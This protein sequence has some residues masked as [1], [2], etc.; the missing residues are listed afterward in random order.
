MK[1]NRISLIPGFLL[2]I[3][4]LCCGENLLMAQWVQ[5]GPDGGEVFCFASFDTLLFAG[6][7]NGVYRSADDGVSWEFTSLEGYIPTLATMPDGDSVM[8]LFAGT[9][10]GGVFF[11]SDNGNSWSAINFGLENKNVHTLAV[12]DTNI[13]A[14][15]DEGVFLSPTNG[16]Y[17]IPISAG[18]TNR[19]INTLAVIDTN[20]YAGTNEGLFISTNNGTSWT[21]TGLTEATV[22]DIAAI[23]TNLFVSTSCLGV[24]RSKDK[25]ANWDTIS[26]PYMDPSIP[27]LAVIDNDLFAGTHQG[28]YRSP[29]NG[30]YWIPANTGLTNEDVQ[31]LYVRGTDLFAGTYGGVYHSTNSGVSWT[32]RHT[33]LK[34]IVVL[35][36]ATR[37]D[38][39]YAVAR[40]GLYRSVNSGDSWT[41]LVSSWVCS[42]AIDGT[43]LYAGTWQHLVYSLDKGDSWDFFHVYPNTGRI[44]SLAIMDPYIFAGGEAGGVFRIKHDASGWWTKDSI[45]Y[46]DAIINCLAVNGPDLFAGTSNGVYISSNGLSWITRNN[47]LTNLNVRALAFNGSDLYAGTDG[48]VFLSTNDGASW[49]PLNNGFTGDAPEIS[50]FVFNGDNLFAGSWGAGVYLSRNNG[51]SWKAVNTGLMYSEWQPASVVTSLAVAGTDL[52]AGTRGTGVW[53]RPISEMTAPPMLL[54]ADSVPFQSEFI[55]VT[56]TED[57]IIYLVPEFTEKDL[58]SIRGICLDSVVA[59]NNSAA[60]ISLSGLEVGNYWL[61]A[62]DFSGILSDL[63]PF[64]IYMEIDLIAPGLSAVDSVS[65]SEFIEVT[66]SEDGMIYLVPVDTD[67]DIE[68]IREVCIDS[69]GAVMNTPVNIPLEGMENGT[70]WLYATDTSGNISKPYAFTVMGVGIEQ[71][72]TENFKIYPNP[73]YT[74]LTIETVT[75]DMIII[76]IT[77][78]NGQLIF[79]KEM[80]GTNQQIYL[81]SFQKGVYFITIRSDDMV[82]TRKIV[83]L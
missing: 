46:P 83:K 68:V 55:E 24:L 27:A 25:G 62:R 72:N 31:S 82:V 32:E 19:S 80:E 14:G 48:G 65:K 58:S 54:T 53:R 7:E 26:N 67:K 33:G 29:S 56:S 51:K 64:T 5:T 8:N 16:E 75:S 9:I 37:G 1:H 50:S 35:S 11:S 61:Y 52:Y 2:L 43:H 71:K 70:Y 3:F 23:D 78:L 30:D 79:S 17:W 74:M 18:L 63:E 10:F 59:T 6:T 41:T 28:I 69:V 76:E 34:N 40:N 73:T 38:T 49:T 77:S 66:S 42:I 45:G 60:Y 39:I 20:L 21:P 36:L 22:R 15:T 57:G 81:S 4:L 44:L 47:G 12:K 13:F